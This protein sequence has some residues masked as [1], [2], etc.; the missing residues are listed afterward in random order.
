VPALEARHVTHRYGTGPSAVTALDDVSLEVEPGEFVAVLGPSGSGKTTLL[1]ILGCLLTPSEGDVIIGGT[2]LADLRARALT[3]LRAR[4]VGFVFQTHNLVPYL[5]AR[6]NLEV[7]GGLLAGNPGGPEIRARASGLLHELGLGARSDHLP[8]ALSVGERQR[9][10]VARAL[11]NRPS[12]LLV[13]EPTSSL[14][15]PQGEAVVGLL[16]AQASSRHVAVVMV[17][18]DRRMAG[19]ADRELHLLDGRVVAQP[20]PGRRTG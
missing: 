8:A 5:T 7:V 17:T 11:L 12:V 20:S 10:A 19:R 13:D 15:T 14:D 16:A 3:D 4:E 1:S 18:H 2:R 6:E 9:V